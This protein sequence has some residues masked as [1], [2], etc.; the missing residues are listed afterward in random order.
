MNDPSRGQELKKL[1][2]AK[3]E[4]ALDDD[5]WRDIVTR[6]SSQFRKA[7]V[8]SSGLMERRE[9]QAL[10]EELKRMGF[11]ERPARAQNDKRPMPDDAMVQKMVAL[12]IELHKLGA[13]RDSSDKSLRAY[14]KRMTKKPIEW[15][16]VK[17][18]SAVIESLKKWMLRAEA[19]ASVSRT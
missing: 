10:I 17:Q 14:V 1:H 19:K 18:M 12:W 3:R 5:T 9:R 2:V 13:V 11:V 4:L 15:L 8:C 16:T 6:I 7:A